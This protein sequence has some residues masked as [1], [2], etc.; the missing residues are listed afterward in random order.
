MKSIAFFLKLSI[1]RKTIQVLTNIIGCVAS[2][3]F[4]NIPAFLIKQNQILFYLNILFIKAKL[5]LKH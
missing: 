4:R 2:V 5:N 1:S 3:L